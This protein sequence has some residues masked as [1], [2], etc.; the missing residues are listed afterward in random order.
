MFISLLFSLTTT[1][2]AVPVGE[3][4][5]N[6]SPKQ[7]YGLMDTQDWAAA[8]E[9]AEALVQA[10]PNN[11]LAYLTLGDALAHYP[12]ED[13]DIYAAF[14]AWMLAKDTAQS[15]SKIWKISKQRLVWSLD[16]SGIVKLIPDL[17]TGQTGWSNEFSYSIR[18]AQ[19]LDWKPR[20]DFMLGA[21]FLTNIPFGEFILEITP[22]SGL[23]TIVQKYKI[24]TNKLKKITIPLDQETLQALVNSGEYVFKDSGGKEII[25][26]YIQD[27]LP[28]ESNVLKEFKTTTNMLPLVKLPEDTIVQLT[29][30]DGEQFTYKPSARQIV[31]GGQYLV[32]VVQNGETTYGD[33][34]IHPDITNTSVNA[35]FNNSSN[36]RK[37]P[38]N[39]ENSNKIVTEPIPMVQ[40]DVLT[41]EQEE[42]VPT[43]QQKETT[44]IV[45]PSAED[46]GGLVAQRTTPMKLG[47]WTGV[48]LSAGYTFYAN[49]K[50]NNFVQLANEE[51]KVQQNFEEHY[52]RSE[53]WRTQYTVGAIVT[54]H[55]LIGLITTNIVTDLIVN[56]RQ[57]TESE[58]P[59]TKNLLKRRST[60]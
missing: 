14:D 2:L 1:I 33:L 37:T 56:T 27:L 49:R 19:N 13:G 39:I 52:N 16:R 38:T 18:A 15:A 57:P 28:L 29:D 32:K 9:S 5:N 40:K 55:L 10:E 17:T 30:T 45:S 44:L 23:P 58:E 48:A 7:I 60:K 25:D 46:F 26:K 43:V 47:L 3:P 21:V 22:D 24:G 11:A 34:V 53:L 59:E 8:I 35:I 12:N 50:T 6:L 41:T 20:T 31:K 51:T 36:R 4:A 42:A 54:S